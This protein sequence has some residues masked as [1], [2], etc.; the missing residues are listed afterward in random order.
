MLYFIKY[1][2]TPLIYMHTRLTRYCSSKREKVFKIIHGVLSSLAII[3]LMKRE[4]VAFL[5]LIVLLLSFMYLCSVSLYC[6][7]MSWSY[8]GIQFRLPC[9][10]QDNFSWV[11]NCSLGPPGWETKVSSKKIWFGL[12]EIAWFLCQPIAYLRRGVCL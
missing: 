8:P 9:T 3:L 10:P 5:T 7:T 1:L 2:N 11:T 6:G 12:C 4:L